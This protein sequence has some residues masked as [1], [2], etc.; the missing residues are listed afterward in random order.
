M[1]CYSEF[2]KAEPSMSGLR[3]ALVHYRAGTIRTQN[4]CE[5]LIKLCVGIVGARLRELITLVDV[6]VSI[7]RAAI[8]TT[9]C[10]CNSITAR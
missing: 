2:Q 5:L 7:R 10:Q 3:D 9:T 8:A 4:N 1:V 6:A